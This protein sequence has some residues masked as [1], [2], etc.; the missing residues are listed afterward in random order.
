MKV[1]YGMVHSFNN[2]RPKRSDSMVSAMANVKYQVSQAE[3]IHSSILKVIISEVI[4][5]SIIGIQV[6]TFLR[7][8]KHTIKSYSHSPFCKHGIDSAF[9]G[10]FFSGI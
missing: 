8:G 1:G 10:D 2:E 5:D 3:I 4:W 9:L 6:D 7:R